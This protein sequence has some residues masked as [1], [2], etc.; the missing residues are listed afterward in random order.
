MAPR[1]PALVALAVP[2]LAGVAWMA[3]SGA[4]AHYLLINLSALGLSLAWIAFGRRLHPGRAFD[5]LTL[6][7]LGLAFLPLL[8]GPTQLSITGN[9]V[10]RWIPLGPLAVHTGMLVLPALCVI[11]SQNER[12]GIAIFAAMLVAVLLQPDAATAFAVTTAAIGLYQS[13]KDWKLGVVAIIGFLATIYTSLHGE[14]APAPHVER[15]I[16]DAF[17]A[18]A[19]T[20]IGLLLAMAISFLLYGMGL[21]MERGTRFALAGSFF[22]FS[23][24]AI[25]SHYPTP[26]IGYGAAPIIGY[27]FALGLLNEGTT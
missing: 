20:G 8:T 18:S 9:A 22:G 7:L 12:F 26:L 3:A 25:M 5:T 14:L 17:H 27:G 16:L 6:V 13:R 11:A 1:I 4:P 2:V 21:Q 10:A 15:V 19:L 23:L 24:M